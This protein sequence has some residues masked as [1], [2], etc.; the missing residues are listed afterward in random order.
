MGLTPAGYL[1]LLT[2]E[3]R[4]V[5]VPPGPYRLVASADRI[6]ACVTD[7]LDRLTRLRPGTSPADGA[8]LALELSSYLYAGGAPHPT[9]RRWSALV[10]LGQALA[11]HHFEAAAYA[12]LAGEWPLVAALTSRPPG[13]SSMP[14]QLWT[15]LRDA[16]GDTAGDTAGG[17][18][19]GHGGRAGPVRVG[20]ELD[21]DWDA[22]VGAVRDG[23]AGR[24]GAGLRNLVEWWWE[25]DEGDWVEFHPFSYPDYDAPLCAAA[26]VVRHR[27][28]DVGELPPDVARYLEA[29]LADGW[30]EPLY[31][32]RSPF[33]GSA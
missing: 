16:A 26:A 9:W 4:G 1:D 7:V 10:A 31:P 20:D 21:E 17:G 23:D 8:D 32:S 3:A 13:R 33:P 2:V 6:R 24:A 18:A 28:L 29:G 11:T 27:G 30:P 12:A 15:L 5:E 25:E 22:L 19:A 14:G